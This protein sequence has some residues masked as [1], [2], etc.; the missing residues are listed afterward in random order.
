MNFLTQ[1]VTK[2]AVAA[3]V[4]FALFTIPDLYKRAFGKAYSS[5]AVDVANLANGILKL[6]RTAEEKK[7]LFA[8]M[9]ELHLKDRLAELP[10]E[11][12]AE[13]K[14][15]WQAAEAE[16]IVSFALA[17]NFN[18]AANPTKPESV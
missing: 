2:V 18:V 6:D 1:T 11:V 15:L 3:A 10:A 8:K 16:Y 9:C 13:Y 7:V 14:G 12:Q 17:E 5:P 4:G